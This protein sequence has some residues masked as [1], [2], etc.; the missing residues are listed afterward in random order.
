VDAAQGVSARVRLYDRLF[1]VPEPRVANLAEDFNHD[2]LQEVTAVLEPAITATDEMRFQ[3]ERLG[4]FC[5]DA[6]IAGVFNRTVSLRDSFK[7]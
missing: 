1:R 2:S 6:E 4:Y 7:P 3:F 5:K